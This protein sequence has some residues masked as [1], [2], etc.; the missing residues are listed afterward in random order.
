MA[1][2]RVKQDTPPLVASPAGAFVRSKVPNW[3]ARGPGGDDRSD[4][5]RFGRRSHVSADVLG[6]RREETVTARGEMT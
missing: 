5:R 3:R 2:D 6:S 4:L 1:L